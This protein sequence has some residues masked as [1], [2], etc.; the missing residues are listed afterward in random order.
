[1]SELWCV[2]DPATSLALLPFLGPGDLAAFL[3]TDYSNN[4]H[5]Y[6]AVLHLALIIIGESFAYLRRFASDVFSRR[7]SCSR[8]GGES[9]RRHL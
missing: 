6:I 4:E 5:L 8:V 1:M 7:C 3:A 9:L 2:L